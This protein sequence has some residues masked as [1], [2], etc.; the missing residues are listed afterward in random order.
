MKY[1]EMFQKVNEFRS[2]RILRDLL[3]GGVLC[4]KL[5]NGCI[6]KWREERTLYVEGL[7]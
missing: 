7:V 6:W 5:S 1:K 3:E 4:D 2:Q